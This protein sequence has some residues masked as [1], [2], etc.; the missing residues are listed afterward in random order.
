M[1]WCAGPPR[2]DGADRRRR[3]ARGHSPTGV[4]PGRSRAPGRSEVDGALADADLVIVE[5]LLSLPLN[6]GAA[7]VVAAACAGRPT[8]LHHHDLPWQ[9]P[10]LAH[11][12][13]PPDDAAWAHVTINELSRNELATYGIAASTIYNAFDPDPAPGERTGLR[14]AVGVPDRTPLL[15]QPTPRTGAQ[16]HRGGPRPRRDVGRH[17]L[18]PRS[19]G[20]RVRARARAP[21]RRR[22]LPRGPRH[23]HRR[24]L[25]CR[26]LR[27]V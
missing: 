24:L 2:V 18:A 5:N 16:E 14:A 8:L 21:G 1:G 6:P 26:R 12:P 23:A 7:A 17:L 10:H 9:R 13:P 22:P 25:H 19:G 20:G 3:G 4:G 11:L 15:L 27:R